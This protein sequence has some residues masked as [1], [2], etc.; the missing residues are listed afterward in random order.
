MSGKPRVSRRAGLLVGLVSLLGLVA[1][2]VAPSA[3]AAQSAG[4][5]ASGDVKVSVGS[6]RALFPRNKQNEPGLAIAL[7]AVTPKVLASG[8]NEE[9]DIEPCPQ[10]A[11]Q[12]TRCPFTAGVGTSGVYFSFDGGASWTA[13]TYRGW[14]ARN[15]TAHVGPIQTLPNYL[16]AGLVSDG[17]PSLA[18]GPR[19]GPNGRFSWA[20]GARLYYANLASN[21][22]GKAAFNGQEAIAVSRADDLAAAAA[23]DQGAWKAPVIASHPLGKNVFSDKENVWADNAAASPFFGN[24]YTCWDKDLPTTQ[25][26]VFSRSTDGG[27]T[28][29]RNLALSPFVTGTALT[30]VIG[31]QIHT[32]S[33]GVVYVFWEANDQP[34][35]GTLEM[36]RSFD[37]GRSFT[38]PRSVARFVEIG[39][40]DPA[41][42]ATGDPR[43]TIDGLAGA[44]T[45]T[46]PSIDIANGA[47]SGGDA[48]DE[49]VLNWADGRRGLNRE[50]AL[51]E[52]STDHGT[53]WSAPIDATTGSDRPN[54]PAVA[55]SPNGSD[56]YLTYDAHLDPWR[57]TMSGA[58]RMQGVVLHADL[59]ANGR[60][61]AFGV[62]HRGGVGDV[63]GSSQ[64]GL[65][66]GFLGDYNYAVA[67]RTSV[68]A[69]WNDVRDAAICPAVD[70]FR[71]SLVT[72]HPL[73]PPW[74]GGQCPATFGNTDIFGGTYL[75]PTP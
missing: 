47:P 48:T 74:P 49:L 5:S 31:C 15:G 23:G 60:P 63:R 20:N 40:V 44:R 61:G 12:G 18:F 57:P 56:L 73:P 70:R 43:F 41:H 69:V 35:H 64:N 24:V 54:F 7:N 27:A 29:S 32:D 4:V 72:K 28:W 65:T 59:N 9:A 67:A 55:I 16:E 75:D 13:P 50:Q 8:A 19:P 34:D 51:L 21:F 11:P 22:P 2:A 33:R 30:G 53:T 25:A 1:A 58:R 45:G 66:A 26:V 3:G 37:G 46:S 62:L 42:V 68:S 38:P 10:A 6:P 52:V 39:K 36:V 17:D 14:T 71:A